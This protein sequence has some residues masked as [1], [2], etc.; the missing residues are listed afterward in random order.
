[1][2]NSTRKHILRRLIDL[3]GD[4]ESINSELRAFS[5]DAED[6]CVVLTM[7]KL[8]AALLKCLSGKRTM[9]ELE[10]WADLIECREDINFEEAY[11][12]KIKAIIHRLA[13]PEI[14]GP[15]TTDLI[16]EWLND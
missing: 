8:K 16:N 12:D 2:S 6:D 15:V 5:W 11:N 4:I 7:L 13:N 9:A 14:N 3:D 10:R 1:M